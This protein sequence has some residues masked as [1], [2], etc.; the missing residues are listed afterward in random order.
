MKSKNT[1]IILLISLFISSVIFARCG[2][3]PGDKVVGKKE[4]TRVNTLVMS[5]PDDGNINGLII[6]SCGKCNLGT[7]EKGCSLSVKVGEKIY[8]VKGTGIH[9]HGDAH[10]NEGFC[11]GVRVAWAEGQVKKD[12]FY[13]ES[14]VLVG[15]DK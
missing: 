2:G 7:K 4:Q 14:F 15:E 11:S 10:G 12:V 13:A 8:P 1:M 5:L 6:T 9:D 3:C